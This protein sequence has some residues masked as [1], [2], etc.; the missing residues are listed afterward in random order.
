LDYGCGSG[1]I[2]NSVFKYTKNVVGVDIN[3]EKAQ[4]KYKRIN[5]E[6]QEN[7]KLNFPNNYFDKVVCVNVIGY[8]YDF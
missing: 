1:D 3:I 4:K 5:F 8:V 7:N 6:Q 2:T